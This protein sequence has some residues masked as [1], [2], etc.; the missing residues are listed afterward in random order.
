MS[1]VTIEL[2]A[3]LEDRL[4]ALCRRQGLSRDQFLARAIKA[5]AIEAKLDDIRRELEPRAKAIGWRT[6][7][8]VFRDVS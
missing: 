5:L 7:E 2:D 1:A 6:E 4:D 8:D 3:E